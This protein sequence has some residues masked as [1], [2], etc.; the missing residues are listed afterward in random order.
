MG[1]LPDQ[2]TPPFLLNTFRW[3][4]KQPNLVS[5]RL[6]RSHLRLVTPGAT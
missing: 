2:A 6:E 1:E 5:G 3:E 4:A